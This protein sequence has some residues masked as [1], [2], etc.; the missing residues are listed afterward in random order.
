MKGLYY[1][2][3]RC[4]IRQTCLYW[5]SLAHSEPYSFFSPQ[6]FDV[7]HRSQITGVHHSLGTL[8]T[9]STDKTLRVRIVPKLP[10]CD[11]IDRLRSRVLLHSVR[12]GSKLNFFT[13]FLNFCT[14][15]KMSL[16]SRKPELCSP[17]VNS[18]KCVRTNVLE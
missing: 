2:Q 4:K 9:A 10:I 12:A 5:L 18:E 13:I 17:I 1:G 6:Y 7:G 14:A 15:R 16:A 11:F 3:S 8:Y